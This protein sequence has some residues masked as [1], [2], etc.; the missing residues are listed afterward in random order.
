VLHYAK[1]C[2]AAGGVEAF[3]VGSELR[4]LTTLRSSPSSFDFVSMLK[5][6]ASEVKA[7]LPGAKIS[8]AADW[9]EYFGHQPS[10]GS[11]DVYFHL[12]PLWADTAIDFIGID[13][14]MPLA[15]WRDGASHLDAVAGVSSIQDKAYLRSQ[16]AGGEGFD[17]YYASAAARDAQT[18]TPISDGAYGKPWV[19]RNKDLVGW[20]SNSHR[21]RPG[22]VESV[23]PTAWVPQSKPIWFTE[24]GCPAVDKGANQPNVFYDVKSSESA[25]P[26][27]SGGQR[28]DMMQFAFLSAMLDHWGGTGPHNPVSSVYGAK[29]LRDDRMA[30]WAWDA[31]P[32]PAFPA[33][34][35]VWSDG[36][37]YARGHWLNGRLSA[38]ALGELINGIAARFDLSDVDTSAVSGLVDGF[39]LDRPLSGREALENLLKAFAIDVV[40]SNGRLIFKPRQAGKTITLTKNDLAEGQR[41]A[42]IF[43]ETRLQELDL[44]RAVRL[45]YVETSLDYRPA[46]V[47][48]VQR[49]TAS[50]REIAL[51]LPA[52]VPQ[53]LAQARVDVALAESWVARSTAEFALTPSKLALEPGDVLVIDGRSYRLTA[54]TDDIA[55]NAEAILHDASVYDA[56]ALVERRALP[57][58]ADVFGQADVV[59][60]DLASANTAQPAAPWMAAQAQPWPG[61]L[62]VFRQTSS[63]SFAVNSVIEA[64]ATMG[65]TL[66]ALPKGLVGRVDYTYALDVQLDFGAL[67]SVSRMELLGGAN[68]VAIGTASTGFELLQFETATLIAANTYRVT[69]LLRAQAGSGPEMRANRSAGQR[70]I[71]MNS[72][73]AKASVSLAEATVPSTWRVGPPSLDHGH[74]AYVTVESPPNL[75]ALR[76]LA[77]AHVKATKVAGGIA[78]EWIRQTRSG[79]DAWELQ[80]VPLS[81]TTEAYTLQILNGTSVVRQWQTT[82]PNQFYSTSSMT[83]D[84]GS[85]P[86]ALNVRV[87]QLSAAVGAGAFLERT[88]NA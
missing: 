76:P 61:R 16:I 1:L 86:T 24:A 56:P 41:K 81:E 58:L 49:S 52:A 70:F 21:N 82:L 6:L 78:I 42:P 69:G 85:V 53:S 72:A 22:G 36:E 84:F 63:S 77:P 31:R 80:E 28:D 29:M 10:D 59:F 55:R 35:D 34:T 5:T 23:T 50:N 75:K 43:S 40:E 71:L 2:A 25:L 30:W 15:D 62:N 44:P 48:Q 11:G 9:S 17:W 3:L 79:G 27:Y 54:V 66:T 65:V 4:G 45:G 60:M 37:N 18:R 33:R 46:A 73:V 13:N 20:W 32:F 14:Y 67:A 51:Q 19:F 7:I 8:Y 57:K 38:V 47:Q 26:Y 83:T 64:Q 88:L 12:D 68:A 87:A 39:V 74:P